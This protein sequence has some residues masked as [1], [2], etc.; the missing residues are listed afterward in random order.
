MTLIGLIRVTCSFLS[1]SLTWRRECFDWLGLGHG[2]LCNTLV[3]ISPHL[4]YNRRGVMGT[5]LVVQW[6]GLCAPSAGWKGFP[7][8]SVVKNLPAMLQTWIQSLGQKYTLEKKIAT[9]SSILAWEIPRRD[10][11]GGLQSM[12]SQKSWT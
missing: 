12:G 4:P 7:G 1:Q 9:H 5:T 11:P 2:L 6:L 8:G 3:S 10:E